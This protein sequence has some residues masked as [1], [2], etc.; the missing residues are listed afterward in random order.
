MWQVAEQG[1]LPGI[2]K[3]ENIPLEMNAIHIKWLR[4]KL[5]RSSIYNRL[6]IIHNKT[7]I[8]SKENKERQ[9]CIQAGNKY[10]H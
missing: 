10:I 7:Y 6:G 4:C 2:E 1:F 3:K 9:I 5:K 8:V